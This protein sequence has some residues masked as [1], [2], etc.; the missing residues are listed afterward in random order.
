MPLDPLGQAPNTE[1]K[2]SSYHKQQNIY[3]SNGLVYFS[4]EGLK[5]CPNAP[6]EKLRWYIQT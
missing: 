5:G 2:Q 4:I 1:L 3:S 6:L